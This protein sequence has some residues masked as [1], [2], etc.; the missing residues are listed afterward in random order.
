MRDWLS[1]RF[2]ISLL[3]ACGVHVLLLFGL[4]APTQAPSENSR[5][6]KVTLA[7]QPSAPAARADAIAARDQRGTDDSSEQA[8]PPDAAQPAQPAPPVAQA[9]PAILARRSGTRH[10]DD[11]PKTQTSATSFTQARQETARQRAAQADA[12]ANY[13][14]AWRQVVEQLGN[15]RLPDATV[16]QAAGKRLTLE[17][18]LDADGA[19]RSTRVRKSSGNAAL[20]AAALKMLREAAPFAPFPPELRHRYPQLTFAYDWRF[21]PGLATQK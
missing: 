8:L 10:A 14:E 7:T 4:I 19:L 16:Q 5:V 6:L 3:I 9:N 13:L 20:D 15:R 2:S 1:S 12:R 11:R 21:L 17:V 18:T